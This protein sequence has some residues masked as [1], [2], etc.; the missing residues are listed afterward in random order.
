LKIIATRLEANWKGEPGGLG[1]TLF[2]SSN[3]GPPTID[4]S[5]LALAIFA[6]GAGRYIKG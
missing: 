1:K 5:D 2:L 6:T 3:L 4:Q